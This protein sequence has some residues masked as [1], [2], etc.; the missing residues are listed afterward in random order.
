MTMLLPIVMQAR[1]LNTCFTGVLPGLAQQAID[2]YTLDVKQ[3]SGLVCQASSLVGSACGKHICDL[4]C[5]GALSCTLVL[6]HQKV[7]SSHY[8]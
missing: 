5:C 1:E 6:E 7:D 8:F 3:G 4:L 2:G